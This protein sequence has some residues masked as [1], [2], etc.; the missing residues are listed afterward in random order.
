MKVYVLVYTTLVLLARW[1][2]LAAAAAGLAQCAN[3]VS[4]VLAAQPFC[5]L[6]VLGWLL[7]GIAAA[8]AMGSRFALPCFALQ[9]E[10]KN[11]ILNVHAECLLHV[12]SSSRVLRLFRYTYYYACMHIIITYYYACMHMLFWWA[13]GS[14][15]CVCVCVVC[16]YA[17]VR[18]V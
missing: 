1:L 15:N 5:V 3:G 14:M 17:S 4:C 11:S 6:Y 13:L 7:A 10:K 9:K 8:R 16:R 2:A 12:G 18:G